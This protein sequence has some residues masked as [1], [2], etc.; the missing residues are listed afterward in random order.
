[1]KAFLPY[2][3]LFSMFCVF[4]SGVISWFWS[5]Y[6]D[7]NSCKK[8][9]RKLVMKTKKYVDVYERADGR[10]DL[11]VENSYQCL[12]WKCKHLIVEKVPACPYKPPEHP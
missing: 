3:Y 1:M 5:D 7:Q 12:N 6:I 10:L 4:I 9:G 8:C 2:L 11:V